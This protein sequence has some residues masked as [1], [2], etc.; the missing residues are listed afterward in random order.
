MPD[1]TWPRVGG[2]FATTRWSLVM[3]AGQPTGIRAA[4]ALAS[5]CETYWHPVY[6]FIRRQGHP[7][8]ESADLTQEFFARVLEKHYFR[9][10]DPARGR[11]RAFLCT[12]VRHFLS[13][14]R[15]RSRALKR[16]GVQPPISLELETAEGGY[17]MEARDDLT[18]EK[19]F[20]RR[21]ALIL[22]E[23]ALLQVRDDYAAAGQ[24]AVFDRLQGLL[25][26]DSPALRYAD[27]GQPL[28]MS[29]GAV[30]VAVHRLRRRFRDALV[31]E[32]AE[33][34]LDPAD[35]DA[36]IAYLLKAVSAT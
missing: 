4:E 30:K 12:A 18:P 16:G 15:D 31:A 33:T 25:T 34:V 11:F 24:A 17:Q 22:I 36:E 35:V 20:D 5:L 19:L 27:L 10:A 29:E 9:S 32:I 3:A 1:D 6:S 2:R 21:W 14:E 28:G 26:G 7:S 23:R 8:E 13:N